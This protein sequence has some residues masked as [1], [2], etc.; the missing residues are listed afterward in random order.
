MDALSSGNRRLGL[1]TD[2]FLSVASVH[3][4]Y[5]LTMVVRGHPVFR[6]GGDLYARVCLL[7]A[8]AWMLAVFIWGEYPSYRMTKF[9]FHLYVPLRICVLGL[10][11]FS[12]FSFIFKVN[13]ISRFF[14]GWYTVDTFALLVVCRALTTW[15]L[16]RMRRSGRDV[17][18]RIVV[19]GGRRAEAYVKRIEQ[20]PGLGIRVNG[21]LDDEVWSTSIRKLGCLADLPSIL[22]QHQADGVVVCLPL[23]HPV[24]ERVIR[25]C[26][27]QGIPVEVLLDSLSSRIYESMFV[28][29]LGIPR[30][31]MLPRPHL[32][33]GRW[34][35]RATDFVVSGL[36][37]FVLSP[38]LLTIALAI[39]LD[40]RG[41]VFFAQ[42]RLGLYG[43]PFRMWKFR[44]MVVDAERRKRELLRY[45]EMSGPVFKIRNDPRVTR[46]GRIL[47]AT[48][49]D[50]LPQLW[51][52]LIG[53]MSL[54]GPRPPI[55]SEVDEY[56]PKH[57]RRLSVKPGITCLWQISGRNQVD[58][59]EWMELDLAYIDNWSYWND[60][61]I[62][63]KTVPAVLSRRGA[64]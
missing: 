14:L 1:L 20:H 9:S 24:F 18:T 25:Q 10:F 7:C 38:I 46:V 49:L 59:E 16:Y 32:Q 5:G 22:Q 31:V 19:G 40:D 39:K 57:R 63:F 52:V 34:L 54:V 13:G 56:D 58:F 27:V 47:R 64:S 30:L 53:D 50:E 28:N 6:Y 35:K 21:Y 2:I 44:S 3:L 29:G 48:S 23:Q 36:A 17:R 15:V 62:L 51:N 43:R 37:L 45:N 42:T 26:E 12:T 33:N 41:P 8:L 11:L 55:P 61:K 4:T 60:L